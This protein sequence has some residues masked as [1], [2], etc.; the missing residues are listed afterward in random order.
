MEAANAHGHVR[1]PITSVYESEWETST[2][3]MRLPTSRGARVWTALNPRSRISRAVLRPSS[4]VPESHLIKPGG[5]MAAG[6]GSDV[7]GRARRRPR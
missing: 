1:D 7:C 4:R 2:R 3:H 6:T 5:N